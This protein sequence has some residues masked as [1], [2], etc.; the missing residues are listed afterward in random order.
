MLTERN[1]PGVFQQTG[2]A[3][4]STQVSNTIQLADDLTWTKGSHTFKFGGDFRRLSAHDDN[5]FGSIRSGHFV[6]D[7]SSPVGAIILDPFATFLLGYPDWELITLIDD[8]EMNGL[9]YS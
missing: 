7:G 2:G 1:L 5:A 6:F 4:P 3:N 8:D 9:G